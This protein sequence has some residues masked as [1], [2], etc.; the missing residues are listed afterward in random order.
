MATATIL[1]GL[2]LPT[3]AVIGLGNADDASAGGSI[4][5]APIAQPEPVA[6]LNNETL[7]TPDLLFNHCPRM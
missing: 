2:A 4:A 5:L 3:L 7:D 1:L 6:P